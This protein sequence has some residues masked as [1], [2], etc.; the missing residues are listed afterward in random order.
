MPLDPYLE[1]QRFK[2]GCFPDVSGI[3][4]KGHAQQHHFSPQPILI[5]GS[6]NQDLN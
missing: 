6:K 1:P 3:S 4:P 5:I 2:G